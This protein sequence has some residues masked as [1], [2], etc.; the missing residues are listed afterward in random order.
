[1]SAKAKTKYTETELLDKYLN[2]VIELRERPGS[3]YAFA[4]YL[5]EEKET[6][7]EYFASIIQ[8]ERVLWKSF[9]EENLM[10]LSAEPAYAEY[11][12]RERLLAFYFTLL[13]VLKPHREYVKLVPTSLG[14][15]ILGSDVL[16]EFKKAFV[17]YTEGLVNLGLE[18][19]EVE[20]RAFVTAK[21][22]EALWAQFLFIL[23]FWKKD[24]SEDYQKTDEAIER[25][26]NLSLD[27]MARGPLDSIVEFGQFLFKNR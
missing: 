5:G 10:R 16:T 18:T 21:Y 11:I 27:L 3:I 17:V 6:I 24:T 14:S 2:Y 7:N 9:F 13:E 4:K 15:G 8:L 12:A 20:E 22:N 19:G 25:S 1:M 23:N 26:V